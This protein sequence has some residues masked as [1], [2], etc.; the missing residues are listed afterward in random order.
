MFLES[1]DFVEVTGIF[2]VAAR[3]IKNS[4]LAYSRHNPRKMVRVWAEKEMRNLKRLRTA[5]IRCPEPIEVREN[6]LVMTFV[7]DRDGWQVSF[8]PISSV[9]GSLV[10][11]ASPR[12]KDAD[13]P[14]SAFPDLYVELML[15]TRKMFI[16]CKLVHADLSEYNILYHVEDETPFPAEPSD[17]TA[18]D[19]PTEF[20]SEQ[21]P[22]SEPPRGHL[23]IIDVSQSVEHD[24][25]H[26]F[27][28]LRADLRNIEDFFSKRGV[29]TVGLRRA[30]EFITRE[31]LP[32][33]GSKGEEEALR[34]WM[35][36]PESEGT[37]IDGQSSGTKFHDDEVFMRSYI[38]RTLNEVYDPERDV[39]VLTR[40]EGEKLIYKDTIGIVGPGDGSTDPA[41]NSGKPSGAQKKGVTFADDATAPGEVDSDD[42]SAEDGEESEDGEDDDQEE[43]DGEPNGYKEK[44]PRGHRHE[45]KEAKK[46]SIWWRT[47]LVILADIRPYIGAQ[48]GR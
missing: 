41:G 47:A 17:K 16:G 43:A 8:L 21:Q 24:H 35:D 48:E 31:Q 23:W 5:G 36:T 22:P 11:R 28:F 46:V 42:H 27:D 7:G 1:S 20:T 45:D 30:F 19:A 14:E 44:R 34:E 12:L 15:M 29:R 38:P 4:C 37:D 10:C 26:A 25:P 40:G 9:S 13:I 3:C 2:Y 18:N 6:V 39:D 32:A 33:E